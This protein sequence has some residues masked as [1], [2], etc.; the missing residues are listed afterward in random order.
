M[1]QESC[2]GEVSILEY[3]EDYREMNISFDRMHLKEVITFYPDSAGVTDGLILGEVITDKYK[4]DLK[5][6]ID[7][8]TF[9][10]DEIHKYKCNPWALSYDLYG[11]VEFWQLLLDLNDMYSATEFTKKTVKVQFL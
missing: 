2:T 11:T 8:K 1:S 9:T 4:H 7:T 6:M 5:N 3:I 10:K